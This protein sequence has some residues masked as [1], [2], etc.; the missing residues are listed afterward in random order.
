MDVGVASVGGRMLDREVRIPPHHRF[1][2][3][4]AQVE[5]DRIKVKRLEPA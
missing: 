3:P 1:R 2:L 4:A 5:A